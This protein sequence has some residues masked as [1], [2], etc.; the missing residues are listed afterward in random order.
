MSCFCHPGLAWKTPMI[1]A[2]GACC[3]RWGRNALGVLGDP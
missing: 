3:Q 1:T 2:N